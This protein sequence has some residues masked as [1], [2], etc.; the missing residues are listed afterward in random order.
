MISSS[1]NFRIYISV[2]YKPIMKAINL[3]IEIY[4]EIHVSFKKFKGSEGVIFVN[5]DIIR[6]IVSIDREAENFR[7]T[8]DEFLKRKKKELQEEVEAIK[9]EAQKKIELEKKRISEESLHNTELE[10]EKIR[11]QGILRMSK[12]ESDFNNVRQCIEEEAFNKLI[13]SFEDV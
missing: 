12:L 11:H 4:L 10:I 9:I 8:K 3:I 5:D 1:I 13:K 2:S 6:K 7:R